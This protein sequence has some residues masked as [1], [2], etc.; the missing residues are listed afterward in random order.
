ML[1]DLNCEP[2]GPEAQA[3]SKEEISNY[4]KELS[5]KWQIRPNESGIGVL[6]IELATKDFKESLEKAN[7]IGKIAD[8]Q[9]HHPEIRVAFKSI[10]V[11]I[12]THVIKGLRKADFIF[13][14]KVDDLFGLS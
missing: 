1:K 14:A 9:W 13:A 12:F 3:L 7:L 2:C 4:F 6:T 8:E 5:G 11:E 10:R